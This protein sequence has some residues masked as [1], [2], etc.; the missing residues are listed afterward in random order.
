VRAPGPLRDAAGSA[1]R[2]SP[3]STPAR[4]QRRSI[5]RRRRQQGS[6]LGRISDARTRK[7][8]AY[9]DHPF[10]GR[11]PAITENEFG[12]GT[13]L[14]EGTYLSDKLQTAVLQAARSTKPADQSRPAAARCGS[15]R[16]R[17]QSA[18]QA[19]ALLL[20]L[21]RRRVKLTYAYAPGTNLLDGKAVVKP[22]ELTLAPW[23]L[24]IIEER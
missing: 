14:Y 20:Q 11:W 2:S 24:A 4:A 10:F 19:T 21:L 6:V 17:G 1:I 7:A 5:P 13:L 18:R 9:Y 16:A 22:A 12:A 23:D 15:C 8:L 3:I